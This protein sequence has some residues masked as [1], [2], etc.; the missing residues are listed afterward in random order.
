MAAIKIARAFVAGLLACAAAG[1]AIAADPIR[2][3]VVYPLT[4]P[5]AAQGLPTV[6]AL[7]Q[8]FD[9]EK[10]TVAGR[11]IE[12]VLEDSAGKPDLGL[13]KVKALVERDKVHLLLSELVS[14]VGAAIA[15][16]VAEQKIP[17]VSNVAL[18]S[19]TRNLKSPYIFRFVPSSF[20]Y[21]YAAAEW[22]KKNGWKKI[23]YIGWNAP[24]GREAAMVLKK[25]LGDPNIVDSLFPNV[26]TA[27]YA[28]YLSK[29][30]P[31]KA[32]GVMAGMW[33]ADS[34]RIVRQYAEFGLMKKMPFFGIASFTSEEL[35]AQMPPEAAGLNSAYIYCG[36]LDTPEN[37]QFVSGFQQRYKDVPGSYPYLGYMAA[38][39]VIQALKDI[40]GH[41][42]DR[43]AFVAALRKVQAKG[44]MGMTSFDEHQGMVGDF[45]TLKVQMGPGGRLQN[46]CGDVMPQ[47]RDPYAL[48]P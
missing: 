15:P 27:D 41:A 17:W 12:L 14:S 16:Y 6:D 31:S 13:T 29:F 22:A 10:Y 23:Y 11:K 45:Y 40:N 33:G 35:V 18:A 38:K 3:G 28:P 39:M 32:D 2:I 24:P 42:E 9:E 43:E 30:D 4:G 8:A 34:I 47:V 37:K 26:G 36:T 44:P 7:K 5:I 21:T 48:F 19:L 46:A 25:I 1:A 20:Q